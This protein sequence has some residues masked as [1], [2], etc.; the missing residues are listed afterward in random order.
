[1]QQ[2]R[3]PRERIGVLIGKGG[4]IKRMI[5]ER[6]GCRLNIDS[7][8]GLVELEEGDNPLNMLRCIEVVRAIG[9]GFNPMIA[10][11]LLDDDLIMLDIIDLSGIATTRNALKRIKGRIIGKGGRMR[12]SI[13]DLIGVDVSVYGKTVA[14]IGSPDQVRIVRKAIEMLAEGSSHPA[15]LRYLEKK[16]REL[17]E[18]SLD[19]ENIR[20][21]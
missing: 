14:V 13:E 4:E 11:K 3:I 20:D 16:R 7:E 12:Q 21:I 19:W 15:V 8:T 1:M 10:M 5:E 9:R 6:T 18:S 17:R 2:I